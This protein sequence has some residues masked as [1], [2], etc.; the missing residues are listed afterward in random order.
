M[1]KNITI[2][3][4]EIYTDGGARGN[5]GPAGIGAHATAD[6]QH[7]FDISKYIGE[8]TNNVAEYVAPIKAL[9]HLIG[10]SFQYSQLDFFLDS[11]LVVKQVKG[12]YKVKQPHLQVLHKQ[13]L[14]LIKLT[15]NQNENSKINFHYIPREKNKIAD[16]LVNQALDALSS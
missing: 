12:E 9:E 14:D 11:L 16:S 10:N 2:N 6:G 8:T 13:I 4:L 5:P 7:L 1:T 3:K 15:R